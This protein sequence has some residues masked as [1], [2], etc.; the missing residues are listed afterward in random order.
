MMKRLK[1]A[2]W[3]I[4]FSLLAALLVSI[5]IP[6]MGI[7]GYSMGFG[8]A[9]VAFSCVVSWFFAAALAVLIPKRKVLAPAFLAIFAVVTLL[10]STR[11]WEDRGQKVHEELTAIHNGERFTEEK[12]A[13]SDEVKEFYSVSEYG[14]VAPFMNIARHVSSLQYWGMQGCTEAF[15]DF[16]QQA[17]E[18]LVDPKFREKLREKVAVAKK[19]IL[20]FEESLANEKEFICRYFEKVGLK[21]SLLVEEFFKRYD[22][23]KKK[24]VLEKAYLVF[25]IQKEYLNTFV[26]VFDFFDKVKDSCFVEEDSYF[27]EH[28]DDLEQFQTYLKILGFMELEIDKAYQKLDL[29]CE[30]G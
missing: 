19:N 23:E 28:D 25:M 27:F 26:E 16:Q 22:I 10:V 24:A 13:Y 2:V 17:Y 11:N 7:T 30:A 12:I 8:L 9:A 1:T 15:F 20:T 18:D 6:H 4:L 14:E 5:K 21:G 3:V 29:S